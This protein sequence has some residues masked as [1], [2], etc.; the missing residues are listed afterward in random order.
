LAK[1]N[2]E[3]VHATDATV[4]GN[5]LYRNVDMLPGAQTELFTIVNGDGLGRYRVY[6]GW[7]GSGSIS[8]I[9][10]SGTTVVAAMNGGAWQGALAT[11]T[12]QFKVS[13]TVTAAHAGIER[14]N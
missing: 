6:M 14:V 13:G 11:G 4:I 12:Y 3:F 10:S 2:Q 5:P 8:L 1:A 9:N 7:N